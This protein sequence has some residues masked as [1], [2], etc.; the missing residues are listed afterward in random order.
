MHMPYAA[1][2]WEE[3]KCR[4]QQTDSISLLSYTKDS[5]SCQT[6]KTY[7]WRIV[8]GP[9]Y[10]FLD[11]CYVCGVCVQACLCD[12][13]WI[14]VCVRIWAFIPT[15]VCECIVC[16]L[17]WQTFKLWSIHFTEVCRASLHISRPAK[18][19]Y[20]TKT[21][22]LHEAWW[23]FHCPGRCLRVPLSPN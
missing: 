12:C 6:V 4:G 8:I 15:R 10:E 1:L 9:P 16:L 11:R 20:A 3:K 23:R 22:T 13:A 21:A 2:Y 18:W 5:M 7:T 17:I 19:K 14:S